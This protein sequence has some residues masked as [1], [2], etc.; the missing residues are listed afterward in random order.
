M[1]W[2]S[3]LFSF[4]FCILFFSSVN[5]AEA[6]EMGL[7]INDKPISTDSAPPFIKNGTTMVPLRAITESFSLQVNWDSATRSIHLSRN[8]IDIKLIIDETLGE[9]NG[10]KMNLPV[11][12]LIVKDRTFVPLRFIGEQLKKSVEWEPEQGNIFISDNKRESDLF[13]L[14]KLVEAEAEDEPYQ[15]KVAV[16]AV[17]VNRTQSPFFQNRLNR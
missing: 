10:E 4:I 8:D 14:S 6:K 16:A 3:L 15:G 1:K 11:A 7:F 9:V 2:Y 5:H 13:W 12:P 17:V